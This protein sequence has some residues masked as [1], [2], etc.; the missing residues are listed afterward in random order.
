MKAEFFWSI[1]LHK[2][3][4]HPSQDR[5]PIYWTRRVFRRWIYPHR[6]PIRILR[7]VA[8]H[9]RQ[10][11]DWINGMVPDHQR[12]IWMVIDRMG[13][14]QDRKPVFIQG[15]I[16]FR[17]VEFYTAFLLRFPVDTDQGYAII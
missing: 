17:S 4:R 1:K 7:G 11:H 2:K 9:Y 16:R 3:E 15:E 5:S 13:L 8:D 6:V 10:M 14:D 12:E